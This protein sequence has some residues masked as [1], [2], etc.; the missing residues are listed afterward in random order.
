MKHFHFTLLVALIAGLSFR[1]V[2]ADHLIFV[3]LIF[4]TFVITLVLVVIVKVHLNHYLG[5]LIPLYAC[6]L[7]LLHLLWEAL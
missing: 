6:N 4:S 3:F 2:L 7:G 5:H 1:L